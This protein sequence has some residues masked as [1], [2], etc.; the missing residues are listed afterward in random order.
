MISFSGGYAIRNSALFFFDAGEQRGKRSLSFSDHHIIR[1]AGY[2]PVTGR[3]VGATNYCDTF[4][5][6]DL[7]TVPWKIERIQRVARYIQFGCPHGM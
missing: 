3:G 5:R 1:D 6:L 7:L 2:F 4:R